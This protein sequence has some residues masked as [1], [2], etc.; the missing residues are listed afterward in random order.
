MTFDEIG[1]DLG[2]TNA[3][4]QQIVRAAPSPAP[5]AS[6]AVCAVEDNEHEWGGW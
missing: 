1:A 3:R 5:R 4:A 2:V 6:A